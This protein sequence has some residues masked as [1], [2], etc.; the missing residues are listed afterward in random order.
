LILIAVDPGEVCGY[1]AIDT[2]T[3]SIAYSD[4]ASSYFVVNFV[5]N[6]LMRT[7]D[8]ILVVERYTITANSGKLSR[9]YTALETIGALRYVATLHGI[10]LELQSRSQK[11]VATNEALIRIGW[12]KPTRGGHVNDAARHALVAMIRHYPKSEVVKTALGRVDVE[13]PKE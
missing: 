12:Y 11:S 4:E 1:V 2:E 13:Q 10:E 3:G 6:T 8:V 5:H 9:Q 7:T